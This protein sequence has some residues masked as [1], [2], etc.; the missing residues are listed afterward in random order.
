MYAST[1]L[2]VTYHKLFK[3]FMK[4][5][6]SK[7]EKYFMYKLFT[8]IIVKHLMKY[9]LKNC[10]ST[11]AYI[12]YDTLVPCPMINPKWIVI[13]TYM[14][15]NLISIASVMEIVNKISSNIAKLNL[16]VL[17]IS[18]VK[19]FV[20]SNENVDWDIVQFMIDSRYL[21]EIKNLSIDKI[22]DPNIYNYKKD[23]QPIGIRWHYLYRLKD[24]SSESWNIFKKYYQ[25]AIPSTRDFKETAPKDM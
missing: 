4:D 13:T 22:R 6:S 7:T 15:E 1:T 17:N 11:Y 10:S 12:K 2:I 14:D 5:A 19:I 21:N 9:S 18:Y 24:E 8:H 16:K 3:R 25:N 23:R 20:I